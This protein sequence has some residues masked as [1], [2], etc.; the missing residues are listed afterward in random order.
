[1]PNEPE[2]DGVRMYLHNLKHVAEELSENIA[3][4]IDFAHPAWI[5]AQSL[6]DV[7]V[8]H[9]GENR[10]SSEDV[11]FLKEH[12]RV[13]LRELHAAER[14]ADTAVE[15]INRTVQSLPENAGLN[16]AQ[17]EEHE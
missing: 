9:A 16:I 6:D 10:T 2:F 4:T 17:K 5:D 8:T 14:I 12:L 11:G 3:S 15:D 13:A 1:M 7:D